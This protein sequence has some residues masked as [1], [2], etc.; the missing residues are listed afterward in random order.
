MCVLTV[1]AQKPVPGPWA[2]V[3]IIFIYWLI[4]KLQPANKESIQAETKWQTLIISLCAPVLKVEK[5]STESLREGG[6]RA[7][8]GGSFGGEMSPQ[9]PSKSFWEKPLKQEARNTSDYNLSA[10]LGQSDVLVR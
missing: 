8:A 1:E 2:N 9:D 10:L 3:D 7:Q 6:A 4:L 5:W